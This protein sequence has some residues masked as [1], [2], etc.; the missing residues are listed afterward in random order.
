MKTMYASLI[1]TLAPLAAFADQTA[2]HC[3]SSTP[4]DNTALVADVSTNPAK[5]SVMNDADPT[6]F[7]GTLEETNSFFAHKYVITAPGGDP[8][9]ELVHKQK[10]CGRAG[11]WS[12]HD[13]LGFWQAKLSGSQGET[14]FTCE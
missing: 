10:Q 13:L 1:L 4:G 3:T 6:E 14:W 5:F 2:F 11:C 9:L 12:D 8:K 7:A